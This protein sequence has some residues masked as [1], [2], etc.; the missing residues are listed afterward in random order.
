MGGRR[1]TPPRDGWTTLH[2]E[3][4]NIPNFEY[5]KNLP[6][7]HWRRPPASGWQRAGGS[8]PAP[9]VATGGLVALAAARG[10]AAPGA[11]GVLNALPDDRLGA[12]D[13]EGRSV[14]DTAI[15]ARQW[16]C[17]EQLA[18]RGVSRLLPLSWPG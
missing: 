14:L 8:H 18:D 16:A 11:V 4:P 9:S 13:A 2:A 3:D 10:L 15:D 5:E 6:A 1:C 7:S 12:E 17:A